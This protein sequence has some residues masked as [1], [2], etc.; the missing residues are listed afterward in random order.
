MMYNLVESRK[1]S[2]QELENKTI[3]IKSID[4]F[5]NTKYNKTGIKARIIIDNE[6]KYLVTTSMIIVKQLLDI[7]TK[8]RIN[9]IEMPDIQCKVVKENNYFKFI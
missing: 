2:L 8:Y 1:I 6:E 4:T 5:K 3:L 7:Q 9:D